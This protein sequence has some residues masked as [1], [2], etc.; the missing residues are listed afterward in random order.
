M[1]SDY[2]KQLEASVRRELSGLEELQAPPGLADRV[3]RAIEQRAAAPW[4]RRAWQT[5]PVPL[6]TASA[7]VLVAAFTFLCFV[8]WQFTQTPEFAS[9]TRVLGGWLDSLGLVWRMLN[10]LANLVVLAFKSL[11]PVCIAGLAMV[12][13]AAYA[14]C[15]GLGTVYVRL[16]FVRR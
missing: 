12:A 6:Q 3:M 1:N 5:W 13:L 10:L 11:G 15:V 7:L 2:E 4:Y 16:A 9:V 8:A 14:A